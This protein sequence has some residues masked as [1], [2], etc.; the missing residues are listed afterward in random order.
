[1]RI[2]SLTLF[3]ILACAGAARSASQATLNWQDSTRD[4]YVNGELDRAAQVMT[5]D[6]P[7]RLLLISPRLDRAVVLDINDR[8]VSAI[9][10]DAFKF[11]ADHASATSDGGARAE[12]AGKFTRLDGP[13]YMF[14]V[15]GKSVLIR[16]HPGVTG[17]MSEEKLWETVPVWRSLMENYQPDSSAL[18]A[19]KAEQKDARVTLVFGTWCPDSKNYIPRL[20]KT[21]KAAANSRLQVKLV[22]IDNQFHEPIDTIQHRHIINVPTVIV[23]RDGR[24]IGRMI[25]TPATASAEQDLA[26]ILGGR[27]PAHTGRWDRGPLVARGVYQYRGP[28]GRERGTEDWELYTTSEG[29]YLAHSLVRAGDA[30]AEVWHRVDARRRPSFVEITKRRGAEITRTRYR[31]DNQS[32]TARLR[33]ADAGVIEQTLAVPERLSFSS[34]V[35]AE[36]LIPDANDQKPTATYLAPMDFDLAAG[37]IAGAAYEAKADEAVRVPA[38]EFRARHITRRTGKGVYELWLHPDVA[39]PVRARSASGAEY[40]LTSIELSSAKK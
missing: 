19:I 31:F 15:D 6:S 25:E 34:A 1:M 22:G 4:V 37:V 40:V 32:M 12:P 11:A 24:E 39:V 29:G 9:T 38:G 36:G 14:S 5:S 7:S 16:S 23:E 17:E 30:T 27:L 13:L 35:A 21:L 33:G 3:L 2:K 10:K 8:S 28:D 20:M 18:A 26:A